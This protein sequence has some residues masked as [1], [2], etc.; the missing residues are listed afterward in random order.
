MSRVERGGGLLWIGVGLWL[1]L[2][3]GAAGI[4]LASGVDSPGPVIVA[5]VVLM[6]TGVVGLVAY[7]TLASAPP[8][9]RSLRVF[10]ILLPC[11]FIISIEAVLLLVEAD[12]LFTEVGEH[13]LATV[14]LAVAAIPFSI[15]IFHRFTGLQRQLADQ[16]QELATVEERERIARELHDDLG[17]LL[18]FL[19]AK[20][21][22]ARELVATGR[23]ELAAE[24]LADLET[25]T[26]T[27]SEQVREAILGLRT[28][29]GPD[30]PLASALDDYTAEFGIQAGTKTAFVGDDAAGAS[31]PGPARYQVLRIVQEAMSNARRHAHAS[32][33]TVSLAEHDDVLELDVADDGEGFDP[34]VAANSGRFGLKTMA[35]RARALGG[36]LDVRSAPGEGTTVR[37][38]VPVNGAL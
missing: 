33:I 7:A 26:R 19:T 6:T 16:A 12:E 10:A 23:T 37:A 11:L 18:G 13:I 20:I 28:P 14:V 4:A 9:L 5:A 38:R 34:G 2:V 17:Q 3:I 27:L 24:E 21:Q 31:L 1:A 15:W 22:A 32:T 8:Q 25:A 36:T 30:R 35:E 29:V